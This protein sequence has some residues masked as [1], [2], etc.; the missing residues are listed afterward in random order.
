[1]EQLKQE[2]E[3]LLKEKEILRQQTQDLWEL[4]SEQLDCCPCII[5]ALIELRGEAYVQKVFAD[6]YRDYKLAIKE[7]SK[8]EEC[9]MCG[10]CNESVGFSGCSNPEHQHIKI[11]KDC[12]VD[13]SQYN[14]WDDECLANNY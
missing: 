8:D 6:D 7:E 13:G 1:M 12:D 10:E 14:G 2:N 4:L 3:K 5:E 11:C 9:D